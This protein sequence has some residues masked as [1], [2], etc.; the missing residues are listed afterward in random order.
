MSVSRLSKQSIQTGFPKQQ[1]VWDQSTSVAGMDAIGSVV[2]TSNQTSVTFSNVPS[3]YTHLQVRG[4]FLGNGTVTC[5]IN[6]NSDS[7]SGNYSFH[8]IRRNTTV[9]NSYGTTSSTTFQIGTVWGATATYPAIFI[10][11]IL[12]YT[13]TNKYKTMRCLSGVE[14]NGGSNSGIEFNSAMW[15]KAGSGTTSPIVTTVTVSINGSG[16]LPGSQ[17]SLYG[18]K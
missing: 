3:T 8:G 5:Y 16:A 13:N 2:L 6:L 14:D 15:S 4:T 10:A 17:F 9:F 11:D 1:T 18:V 7:T 12:D